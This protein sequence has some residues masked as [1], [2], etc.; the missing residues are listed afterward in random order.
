M[1]VPRYDET[2]DGPAAFKALVDSGPIPRVDGAGLDAIAA[3]DPPVGFLA[4]YT[5]E[6]VIVQW[7]GPVQSW[8]PPW[9]SPW[10]VMAHWTGSTTSA[11]NN[12]E[13][14]VTGFGNLEWT[15][16]PNRY[17]RV[18][19]TGRLGWNDEGTSQGNPD[20]SI[21][22]KVARSVLQLKKVS[23]NSQILRVYDGRGGFMYG[24]D[25]EMFS[26][27]W[28]IGGLDGTQ[29]WKLTAVVA[30]NQTTDDF[31]LSVGTG[32]ATMVLIEDIGP[33][34]APT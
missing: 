22:G 15:A 2:A 21:D 12:V 19:V 25:I 34:G 23:D 10:G 33:S 6:D 18:T 7:A 28:L 24:D 17:Y 32:A 1:T 5:V 27:T 29:E 31:Y 3:T 26:T 4:Y 9:K 14:V 11:H 30:N 13:S 20:W 8:K 16:Y